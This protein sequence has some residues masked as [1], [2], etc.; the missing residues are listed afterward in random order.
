M[1]GG[2]GQRGRGLGPRLAQRR[3]VCAPRW[4]GDARGRG[5]AL[6]RP[7]GSAGGGQEQEP[8][9]LDTDSAGCCPPR[10]VPRV[11][12]LP[13]LQVQP[14]YEAPP[15]P[16]VPGSHGSLPGGPAPDCGSF[17]GRRRNLSCLLVSVLRSLM[18]R[19]AAGLVPSAAGRQLSY[20]LPARWAWLG[21]AEQAWGS[22]G[23]G[24]LG[25]GGRRSGCSP[26]RC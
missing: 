8:L 26:A 2:L 3:S 4:D 5:G 1:G 23:E 9:F 19:A 12:L 15:C 10:P 13:R 6:V 18:F 16:A 25:Q 14:S 11:P 21:A 20:S 7:R 17:Q 24:V 22:C